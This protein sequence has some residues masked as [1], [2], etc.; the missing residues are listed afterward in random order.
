MLYKSKGL[1]T[2]FN[3]TFCS[4]MA[5]IQHSTC[6]VGCEVIQSVFSIVVP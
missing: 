2:V 6:A 1:G 3:V 5:I 4:S